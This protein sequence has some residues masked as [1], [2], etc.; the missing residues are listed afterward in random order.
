MYFCFFTALAARCSR[1]GPEPQLMLQ[2]PAVPHP[3]LTCP[4]GSWP[5]M[6]PAS[7]GCTHSVHPG[8]WPPAP[9]QLLPPA[10]LHGSA[11]TAAPSGGSS[12]GP[13]ASSHSSPRR[14]SEILPKAVEKKK[15]H[16]IIIIEKHY[17]KVPTSWCCCPELRCPR[18][19]TGSGQPELGSSQPTPGA[20]T[21]LPTQPNHS[22]VLWPLRSLPSLLW[23][24]S[25]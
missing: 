15:Q 24:C 7:H 2:G 9:G 25:L 18:P 23:L 8:R 14:P 21:S 3:P 13:P 5:A 4:P 10:A 12:L 16:I 20:V 1:D 17:L 11:L 22:M 6:A 19:W